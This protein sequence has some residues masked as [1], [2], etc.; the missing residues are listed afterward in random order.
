MGSYACPSWQEYLTWI[1]SSSPIRWGCAILSALRRLK[2][3]FHKLYLS[4]LRCS[5]W[6]VEVLGPDLLMVK[7]FLCPMAFARLKPAASSDTPPRSFLDRW[8]HK[9]R[10]LSL[11]PLRQH[12]PLAMSWLGSGEVSVYLASGS[13]PVSCQMGG[14]NSDLFPNLYGIYT[15]GKYVR[16]RR[17]CLRQ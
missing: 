16:N 11:V 8:C 14:E 5:F 15:Q 12:C 2:V 6:M 9:S 13:S 4:F 1:W 7:L 10:R 17:R 3:S